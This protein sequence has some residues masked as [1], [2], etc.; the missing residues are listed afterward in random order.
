M[1]VVSKNERSEAL[2][3][4]SIPPTPECDLI[5]KGGITSGLVYPGAIKVLSEHYRLRSIGG[6]SAGA[7]AAVCGAAAEFRRRKKGDESGFAELAR[8]PDELGSPDGKRGVTRM[9]GLFRAEQSTQPAFDWLL[10]ALDSSADPQS[11]LRAFLS[12][13]SRLWVGSLRYFPVG[14]LITVLLTITLAM[15]LFDAGASLVLHAVT[16]LACLPVV[17]LPLLY[18]TV[19]SWRAIQRNGLGLVKGNAEGALS[20]WLHKKIQK[21]AG[22]PEHQPLTFGDLWGKTDCMPYE[23]DI[24]LRVMTTCI[25][26]GQ[27]Y[28]FP[29]ERNLKLYFKPDELAGYLPA[30]VIAHMVA[31]ARSPSKDGDKL[32]SEIRKQGLTRLPLMADLPVLLAVRISLSFP[33]LLSAVPLYARRYGKTEGGRLERVWFSDGGIISNFPVHYFDALIPTRPTFGISLAE[34]PEALRDRPNN[35][36][37]DLPEKNGPREPLSVAVE[38]DGRPSLIGLLRGIVT[39]LHGWTDRA[40]QRV[41]GYYDRVATVLLRPGEG[42]LNLRMP[43]ERITA[44]SERGACAGKRLVAHFNPKGPNSPEINTTWRNHR[45]VRYRTAGRLLEEALESVLRDRQATKGTADDLCCAHKNPPSYPL[46]ADQRRYALQVYE[47]LLD[48]A[49]KMRDWRK[50]LVDSGKVKPDPEDPEEVTIYSND[51]PKPRSRLRVLPRE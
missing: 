47:A 38:P 37:V 23:R 6:A 43:A 26:H 44:L 49:G 2:T 12:K 41:P 16:V 3:S 32:E 20:P 36:L 19:L 42:G 10:C 31:K 27:G 50:A 8:M 11:A 7:I 9:L 29:L 46:K 22:L 25:S 17:L 13:A 4:G 33:I 45:W 48:L 1:N 24:D 18:A 35:D 14:A 30:A 34:A 5:M 51:Y 15:A 28:S 40:Q 21:L 39:T